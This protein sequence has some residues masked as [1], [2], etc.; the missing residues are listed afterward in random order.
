MADQNAKRDD[1]SIVTMLGVT[2]DAGAEIRRLLV[3]PT[4][5]RLKI[6]ATIANGVTAAAV[7]ADN[8]IVR[9]DGG[10][11]GIQ[12]SG[13]LIDDSNNI[14]GVA[15][16]AITVADTNNKVGLTVTQN[17]VTNNPIA[18]TIINAG[19][20]NGLFIDQNG[21]G[22]SLNIDSESTTTKC[23]IITHSG[24][25]G[26]NAFIMDMTQAGTASAM[27]IT[28]S[29][30]L[31]ANAGM[32]QLESAVAQTTG[33]GHL[34]IINTNAG[35]S[36]PLAFLRQDG[37]S[38]NK[39][40]AIQ[41]AGTGDSI[42]IDNNNIGDSISIDADANSA[43]DMVGIRFNIANAGAGLEYAMEFDGSEIVG[44]AIGGA[45]DKKIRCQVAGTD[46]FIPLHTA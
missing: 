18:A 41:N 2:D 10:A 46:Y 6:S 19:T 22:V 43:S 39:V 35:T 33:A 27:K 24:L 8:A 28:Q 26:N 15:S 38:S 20:G 12:N 32:I 25:A 16:M 29:G 42:F 1:N 17:D 4:T 13:I 5:G 21:A 45:Q 40:L 30:V 7:I 37:A 9:G 34:F 36:I 44:A 31:G 11:R 23:I 14:T 3:D